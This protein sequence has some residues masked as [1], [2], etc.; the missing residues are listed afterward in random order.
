MFTGIIE[1][2]GSVKSVRHG[3]RSSVMTIRAGHVLDGLKVGESINTNGVCLTVTKFDG[4]SFTADVMPETISRST[5]K[6]LKSGDP[7]NL[8]RA[9]QL[10]SRLGG[11]LVSGHVDGVGTIRMIREDDNAVWITIGA[12]EAMLRY[13]VGK[14][15]V[16]I[17]GISLTVVKADENSFEVSIIP[18]TLK[19]TSLNSKKR[20]SPVNI[21]CDLIA[22]YTEKLLGTGKPGSKITKEFLEDNDFL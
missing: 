6:D 19:M 14:G 22:K 4:G 17:D 8:E 12:P 5:L 21:E 7:V 9:L 15:S 16:A 11:H 13:I 2:T 20:G 18:H 10:S 1:E 3:S